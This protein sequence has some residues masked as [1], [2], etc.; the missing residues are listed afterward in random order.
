MWQTVLMF[1]TN[2]PIHLALAVEVM[3]KISVVIC[4]AA[5]VCFVLR[6]SS[7]A[8]RHHVWTIAMLSS[9][10]VPISVLLPK[11]CT[12]WN[13]T[14]RRSVLLHELA[15]IKRRDIETLWIANITSALLWFHP[16]VWYVRRQMRIERECACDDMVLEA[17]IQ[18]SRQK[19]KCR[20]LARTGK[21]QSTGR[22]FLTSTTN[23]T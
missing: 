12:D 18:P 10:L 7:A 13:A 17:G 9:L 8:H 5:L 20:R 19:D 16:L 3:L 2:L 6:H 21:D 22:S 4:V 11:F 15:H 23:C 14:K 1:E